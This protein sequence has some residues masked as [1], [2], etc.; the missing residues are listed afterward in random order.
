MKLWGSWW[1]GDGDGEDS[2][3][4]LLSEVVVRGSWC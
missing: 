1:G 2:G 3:L 4:G